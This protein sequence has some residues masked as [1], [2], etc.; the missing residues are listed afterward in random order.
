MHERQAVDLLID[1]FRAYEQKFALSD[2]ADIILATGDP[3]D[4]SSAAVKSRCRFLRWLSARIAAEPIQGPASNSA[5]HG[6]DHL[7]L[8]APHVWRGRWSEEAL[9]NS[10]H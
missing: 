5:S 10:M 1:V 2:V 3:F 9:D 7:E 8:N 6:A 4:L